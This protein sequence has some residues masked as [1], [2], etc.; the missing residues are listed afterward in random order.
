MRSTKRRATSSA[1]VFI[2]LHLIILHLPNIA[3]P[4]RRIHGQTAR[5]QKGLGAQ[6]PRFTKEAGWV[7]QGPNPHA[8]VGG[9]ADKNSG[10]T[11]RVA[12]R[13]YF[14]EARVSCANSRS[15]SKTCSA[16]A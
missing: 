13:A 6:T 5:N 1:L 3:P 15:F 12:K 2:I 10:Q 8:Q 9:G 16:E 14:L 4:R 11:G 7:L